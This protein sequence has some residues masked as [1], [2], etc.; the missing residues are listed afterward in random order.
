MITNVAK[1]AYPQRGEHTFAL[2]IV[3]NP[4][5]LVAR[6]KDDGVAFDPT[7]HPTPNLDASLK[8]RKE[9]GLGILLV[10]QIMTDIQYQRVAGNNIVTLRKKLA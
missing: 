2:Q 8:E 4:D 5:E 3:G 9:G 10:R 6:I 1:H 7:A